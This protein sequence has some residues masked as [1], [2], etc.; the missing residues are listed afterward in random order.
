[1]VHMHNN[2]A[3]LLF[4]WVVY[5][6]IYMMIY[7]IITTTWPGSPFWLDVSK[8]SLVVV[9]ADICW[10]LTTHSKSA[11]EASGHVC[12]DLIR[13]PCELGSSGY[14]PY[15]VLKVIQIV[16][17][18]IKPP[19]PRGP[20]FWRTCFYPRQRSSEVWRFS[21]HSLANLFFTAKCKFKFIIKRQ[22]WKPYFVSLY[23][24]T[25]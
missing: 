25:Q 20:A 14:W 5:K 13:P 17:P 16:A 23:N 24:K 8:C 10:P 15:L 22:L 19:D 9:K 4:F 18:K 7:D 3:S 2:I 11:P 12:Q 6:C 1:M 21:E